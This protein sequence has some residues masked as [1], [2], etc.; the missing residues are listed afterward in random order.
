MSDP[1]AQP[2]PQP[3]QNILQAGTSVASGVIMGL[4]NSPLLLGIVLINTAFIV[5]ASWFLLQLEAYRHD[6]RVLLGELLRACIADE[7]KP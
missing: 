3:P 2:Q 7:V 6:E 1:G 4:G 5:G